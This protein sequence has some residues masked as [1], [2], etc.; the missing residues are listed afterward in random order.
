M[1][2]H[3]I[4]KGLD[5]PI[6]GEPRQ[7]IA[8]AVQPRRVALV[9]ADSL[10]LR[11]RLLVQVGDI[12]RRGQPLYEDKRTAGV[13]TTSPAAGKVV[14]IHRGE[15]RA[16][17][18]VVVELSEAERDGV[19]GN[20]EEQTFE[21]FSGKDPEALS[22]E[23]IAALL[24]ESGLWTSFRSRPFSKVPP[25]DSKPHA[26]FVTAIETN[27]LGADVDAALA[28]DEA[29]FRSGLVCVSKLT[30]GKTVVC[31]K[32]DSKVAASCPYGVEVEEF[33]GPH[34]AG[35]VGLHIHLLDPVHR[36]KI[37]WHLHYQDVVSIG[38]LVATGKL[39]PARTIALGGP[40]VKNPRLL[41]TRLGAS[42]D[43]ILEGELREGENRVISG[44]VLSGRAAMG[45]VHGY[46]GRYHLQVSAIRE[47]RE[48]ELLGWITPGLRKYS[49]LPVVLSAFC[50]RRRFD[51][52]TAMHG[53]KRA[54]VPV[55]LYERVFPF[56]MVATYLLRALA[57][58]D[59]EFAEKLGCLELDEEDV[60]L[61]TFVCP[62]KTDFGPLLRK[63]L[64]LI[65]KEG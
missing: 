24:L 20:E 31:Q 38:K 44:S 51:L 46:L 13:V 18:S 34:P 52:S 12:V 3:R 48:R 59:I 54:I 50:R 40:Q 25:P 30:P 15:R 43:D 64:E 65:E 14:A 33:E 5:L 2:V 60:A 29:H 11:P 47:G 36:G 9:A 39:D 16:L 21:S 56:D 53:S 6:A 45:E 23:E 17:Q 61:S 55:G 35:C 4:R 41:R 22:R 26:L 10:G 49:V 58:G 63:T 32:V 27:P 42:L 37:A 7:S 8:V 1:A 19:S 28:G 62:G 57:A